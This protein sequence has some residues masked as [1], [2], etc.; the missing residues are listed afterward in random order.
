MM[1]E[2][3]IEYAII[4]PWAVSMAFLGQL[5]MQRMQLSQRNV[6]K[7]RPSTLIIAF[8]GQ[9]FM[10]TLQLSQSAEA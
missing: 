10:Q 2:K 8:T 5:L 7:G 6:Q 1:E 9:P 4:D 3:S